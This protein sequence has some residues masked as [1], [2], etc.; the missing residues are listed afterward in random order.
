MQLPAEAIAA[1]R[2]EHEDELQTAR[3]WEAQVNAAFAKQ[4]LREHWN[5]FIGNIDQH[6][7][8]YLKA[9]AKLINGGKQIKPL[10]MDTVDDARV[11]LGELIDAAMAD[12]ALDPAVRIALVRNLRK[13]VSALEEYKITGSSAVLDSISIL[14]GQGFF[15]AN[16]GA[17]IQ[18]NS[19]FGRTLNSVV[20]GLANAMTIVLGLPPL[21]DFSTQ[22][23]QIAQNTGQ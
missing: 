11:K 1:L 23:F 20:G 2:I 16:Y 17:A 22:L 13:L 8:N 10:A 15:D 6:S 19:S 4:N 18:T 9:H 12:E 7:L 14:Y 21:A 5:T 3:H